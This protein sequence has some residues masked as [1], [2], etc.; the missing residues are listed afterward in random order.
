MKKELVKTVG[1]GMKSGIVK[2]GLKLR[3]I[4]PELL[5]A[6]GLIAG[7][8]AIVTACIA[9]K[10]VVEDEDKTIKNAHQDLNDIERMEKPEGIDEKDF[11][12]LIKGK[13]FRVYRKLAIKYAKIYGIPFFLALMSVVCILASHGILKKRYISTT[14]AYKALDEAFKDYRERIKDAVG[15]ER[16]LHYFNGTHEGGEDTFI[17]EDGNV[18]TTK[19][20]VQDTPK[21]DSPYEF[22]FNA[23]TAPGNWTANSDYNQ[24]FLTSVQNWANDLLNARGHLFLNEVLDGLGLKRV[25]WG[26]AV[27]WL[28]GGNGDDFVDFGISE[29]V[30]NAYSDVYTDVQDGY[31]KNIHLNFNVDGIIWM[32]I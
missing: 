7:G 6:A 4:S 16:E 11:R 27:G 9:T 28:K 15:E 25:P 20:I 24:M 31:L 12:K 18:T 26:Q 13:S 8:A 22:D 14:L 23:R 1:T 29:F 21:K 10:K 5:L 32:K 3:K 2:A 30:T 17:D 19:T